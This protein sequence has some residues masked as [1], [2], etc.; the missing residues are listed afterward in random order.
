MG[1]CNICGGTEFIPGPKGRLTG[2]GDPPR[3]RDCK[4]LERHRSLRACLSRVPAELLSWR[5]ALHFAPDPSLD[6]L[7]FGSYEG[8]RYGG[9]NSID[10]QAIDRPD[11]S[12]DFISLSS[13]LEFVPDDRQAFSEL[14]RIGSSGCI[15]HC[16]F[17]PVAP[18]SR[19]YD[20][21]HGAFGRHHVYGADLVD[22][23]EIRP[24]GLDAVVVATVDPVTGV[25][26]P[27]HFFCRRVA[28]AETLK[29]LGDALSPLDA[30]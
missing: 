17:T 21:P 10:L 23:F 1:T 22:R 20:A 6:P 19:H 8:S 24:R 14:L 16:T 25:R 26:T 28:D 4:S 2:R 9:D 7:W 5:R 30:L 13:V 15:I 3:C 29:K 12:Y 18:V 27:T 11:G